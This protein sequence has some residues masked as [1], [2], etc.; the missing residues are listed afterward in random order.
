[1]KR[2]LKDE[3]PGFEQ[4]KEAFS[5]VS[6]G[7]SEKNRLLCKYIFDKINSLEQPSEFDF[8]SVNIEHILPQKP[9]KE[10]GLKPKDIKAYVNKLGNLTLVHK[11]INS[12]IGNKVIKEKID[13]LS[14]S[15]VRM[16]IKLVEHFKENKYKWDE[17]EIDR[18]HDELA[19]TA[20]YD[21][22]KIE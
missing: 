7:R 16:T 13:V 12:S 10:W 1:M 6:Y 22:W 18:R 8:S 15:G 5:E 21:A 14:Q 3:E 20:Y 2:E 11:K 17:A 9:D 4:F 19:K